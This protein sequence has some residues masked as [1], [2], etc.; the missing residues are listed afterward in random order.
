MLVKSM[1]EAPLRPYLLVCIDTESRAVM[2][3]ELSADTPSPKN[4]LSLLVTSMEAPCVDESD[5]VVPRSVRLAQAETVKLL[6]SELAQL[7]IEFELA[8]QLPAIREFAEIAEGEFFSR[9]MG[10]AGGKN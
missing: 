5:S 2:G 10:Y 9:Q 6:K 4:Y 1:G 3:S 7:S 8:D